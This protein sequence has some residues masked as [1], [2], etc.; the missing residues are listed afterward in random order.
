MKN[1]IPF[2]YPV[3]FL[4]IILCPVLLGLA[5]PA[6]A[7]NNA[8]MLQGIGGMCLDIPGADFH[9]GAH[10][11]LWPCNSTIAQQWIYN[12]QDNTIQV[13]GWC[14]DIPG[15]NNAKGTQVQIWK[16]NGGTNQQWMMGDG[17]AMVQTMDGS[18]MVLDAPNPH[19]FAALP[20]GTLIQLWPTH[21]GTNQK[22]E[23]VAVS[24]TEA[25]PP[26][27]PSSPSDGPV[28]GIGATPVGQNGEWTMIF[29]DEFDGT[30]LDV[31]KWTPGWGKSGI[32]GPVNDGETACYDSNLV[33][34]PGDGS[35][36]LA[37]QA[38]QSTCKGTHPYTGAL[39]DTNSHFQYTYGYIEFRAYLPAASNGKVANWPAT[40]T[41]GQSWPTN[42]ENDTMEGLGG[43]ACYHFHSPQGGPGDCAGDDFTG[44]HIFASD[45]E[46][47]S[48]TY[49]YDGKRVG[50]I[51]QGITSAPQYIILDYTTSS[52]NP[53]APAEML[54][55]YVR[56]WQKK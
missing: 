9:A 28:T 54:V 49:Y 5:A 1:C 15:G 50:Q 14:L 39:V 45:W 56:V 52:G 53:T 25:I 11:Q 41:D 36:H 2:P 37:L 38:R 32:T 24:S 7:D 4:Y 35:L 29:N 18:N 47:G 17:N 3:H 6:S 48:V 46:P 13:N 42:G 22:W 34:L 30:T 20:Q 31:A 8:V 44:W 55:D 40:W 21:A 19:H 12:P 51:T 27:S 26:A 33:T 16:C 23:Q 43:Q 10:V